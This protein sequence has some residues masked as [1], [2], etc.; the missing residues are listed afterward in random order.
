[1][2]ES[3]PRPGKEGVQGRA[4]EGSPKDDGSLFRTIFEISPDAICIMDSTG[5]ILRANQAAAEMHG[6]SGSSEL[7]GMNALDLIAPV[8]R[9]RAVTSMARTLETGGVRNVQYRFLRRDGSVF[10][11]LI[12]DRIIFQDF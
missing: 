11:G 5:R 12:L 9:E 7:T 4:H 1:M 3:S 8:D 6:Y 10:H 2:R